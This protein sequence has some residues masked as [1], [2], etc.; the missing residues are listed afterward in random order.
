MGEYFLVIIMCIA[1]TCSSI[2]TGEAHKGYDSCYQQS[3]ITAEVFNKQYPSS[4]GQIFC[5]DKEQYKL[6]INS[7]E[8]KIIGTES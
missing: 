5:L 1:G 4:E 7:T 2:H 8:E 3:T 6:Y